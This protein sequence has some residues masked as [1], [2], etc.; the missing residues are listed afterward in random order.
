MPARRR[1]SRKA[2]GARKKVAR[3][4]SPARKGGKA[5][6]R[7]RRAAKAA[8][9]GTR[10]RKASGRKA[11]SIDAVARR[12]VA[13]A[14]KPAKFKLEDLYTDQSVS[15]ESGPGVP[16]TGL[17]GLRRKMDT[18][19]QI[20]EAQTWRPVSVLTKGNKVVIEWDADVTLRGGRKVKFKEVAVHEVKGGKIASERYYYDPGQLAPPSQAARPP[21]TPP[22]STPR[23][24]AGSSGGGISSGAASGLSGGASGSS[25]ESRPRVDPLDL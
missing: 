25:G 8:G 12:I 2:G 11:P 1:A 20:Q 9:K 13:A 5:A 22:S 6:R 15:A 4:R 17:E 19:S 24:M 23:P 7:G 21:T 3:K 10:A 16:V 14:V 18:W